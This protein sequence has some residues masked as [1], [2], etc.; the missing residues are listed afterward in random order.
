MTFYG[1]GLICLTE[2]ILPSKF[3]GN[4]LDYQLVEE[5]D[6]RGVSGLVVYVSPKVG[7]IDESK[8][9][10]TI[11]KELK[12]GGDSQRVMAETWAQLGTIKIKRNYPLF[13]KTGKLYPL[14]ISP[15]R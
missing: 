8:I 1:A 4:S 9:I 12:K 15:R 10:E 11:L 3:G 6:K 13:T 7:N 5:D 14:H 2:E